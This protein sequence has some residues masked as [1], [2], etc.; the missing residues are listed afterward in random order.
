MSSVSDAA[1]ALLYIGIFCLGAGIV[2]MPHNRR[3]SGSR[4]TIRLARRRRARSG[5]MLSSRA[6][7]RQ[8]SR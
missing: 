6:A 4:S 2:A 3:K 7:P 8:T 5:N 1:T